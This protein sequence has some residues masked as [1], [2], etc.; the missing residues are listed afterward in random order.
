MRN[1][2]YIAVAKFYVESV[3]TMGYPH[4]ENGRPVITSIEV[5][6]RPVSYKPND[7]TSENSMFWNASPSGEMKLY[8]Q[9]VAVFDRFKVGCEVYLP[10]LDADSVSLADLSG[11]LHALPL[12]L[13]VG[14]S[15]GV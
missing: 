9:N 3:K 5:M 14:D 11:A 6:L 12:K 2:G 13:D 4:P 8:I 10:L 15:T 1:P 7:P